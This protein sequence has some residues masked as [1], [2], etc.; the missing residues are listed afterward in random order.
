MDRGI[1]EVDEAMAAER[2][3]LS[4][5]VRTS[6]ALLRELLDPGFVEVGKS[7]RKWDRESM[8]AELPLMTPT[9][10]IEA[11]DMRG[12][13]IAPGVVH[14]TYT[15]EAGGVRSLRGSLWRR[16]DHGNWRLYYHQGTPTP[17]STSTDTDFPPS[18]EARLR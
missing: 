9:A 17:L 2:A 11:L 4:P 1:S 6:P 5:R 10:P 18:Q 8:L 16:D 3:L 14:L 13:L 15:A 12:E 7:G